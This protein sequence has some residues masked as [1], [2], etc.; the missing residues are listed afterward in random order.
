MFEEAEKLKDRL[1]TLMKADKKYHVHM[2]SA[3]PQKHRDIVIEAPNMA[4]AA[5]KFHAMKDRDWMSAHIRHEASDRTYDVDSFSR[6]S[7]LDIDKALDEGVFD[8]EDDLQKSRHEELY[9]EDMSPHHGKKVFA[10]Y[11]LHHK[12]WSVRHQGKVIA[13]TKQ[14]HLKDAKFNVSEKGRQKVIASKHKNVHAGVVGT[15]TEPSDLP[16]HASRVSYNPYH[17]GHFYEADSPEKPAIHDASMVHMQV[18]EGTDPNGHQ[19]RFPRVHAVKNSPQ[20]MRKARLDAIRFE[21]KPE[22]VKLRKAKIDYVRTGWSKPKG[23]ALDAEHLSA[24]D[25]RTERGL[26]QFPNSP[27]LNSVGQYADPLK[28]PAPSDRAAIDLDFRM[29]AITRRRK[30]SSQ[31]KPNLPQDT[32]SE[33]QKL[34]NEHADHPNVKAAFPNVRERWANAHPD[35]IRVDVAR[36]HAAAEGEPYQ[37]KPFKKAAPQRGTEPGMPTEEDS[38]TVHAIDGKPTVMDNPAMGGGLSES[39]PT[40]LDLEKMAIRA[41]KP[42]QKI[43]NPKAGGSEFGMPG[44]GFYSYNHVLTPKQRQGGYSMIVR[45]RPAN[46]EVPHHLVAELQHRGEY[47]GGVHGVVENGRLQVEGTEIK[48][49]HRGKGLGTAIYEG[50][51]AH[52]HHHLGA[53]RAVGK[54]HSSMA[55]RVHQSLSEK[56][57]MSYKPKKWRYSDRESGPYDDKMKPY[58]YAIKSEAPAEEPLVKIGKKKES[59]PGMV[60]P[61]GGSSCAS[62]DFVSKDGKNCSNT[63]WQDWFEKETGKRTS[64]IPA[65]S[66]E[67]CC[68]FYNWPKARMKK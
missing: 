67:Y 41:I 68:N 38:K 10:Y 29:A 63:N 4:E 32:A 57:G 34:I 43:E 35:G 51:Y 49:K 14:L 61:R 55:S 2:H 11:N 6:H 47:A 40:Y 48:A 20:K 50:L 8:A 39:D 44:E 26:R 37:M 59:L 27:D 56:H 16:K 54:T 33:R 19:V 62:C 3:I 17:A 5:A 21:A 15:L 60:V 46:P 28:I 18:Q 64:L 53:K 30:T 42:G 1:A 23:S 25:I 36:A 66:D 12:V 24:G 31:A 13:H 9:T 58:S 22:E 45:H 52:A 7:K 65:P